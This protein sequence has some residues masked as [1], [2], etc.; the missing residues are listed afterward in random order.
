MLE[1]PMCKLRHHMMCDRWAGPCCDVGSLI[2]TLDSNPEN[3]PRFR[4][5][6]FPHAH[7]SVS[8]SAY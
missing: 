2:L 7:N 5:C 6:I 1:R 4:S 3:F 8:Y